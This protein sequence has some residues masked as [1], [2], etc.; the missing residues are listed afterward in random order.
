MMMI[1]P[2]GALMLVAPSAFIAFFDSTPA[3]PRLEYPS[4]HVAMYLSGGTVGSQNPS[5]GWTYGESVEI[6]ARGLYVDGRLEQYF[7]QPQHVGYATAHAGFILPSMHHLAG[8]VLVGYRAV[9][10]PAVNGRE[11]GV[12]VALPLVWSTGD[13][14]WRFES[15]YVGN[16]HG[17]NW[18]Y[19]VQGEWPLRRSRYVAGVKAE[20]MTLPIRDRSNI[21]WL[22]LTAV[23]GV[24]R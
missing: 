17:T 11:Q 14:W 23:I 20:T 13:R 8:G 22:T 15:F 24:H 12:E 1:F 3:P 10:G 6:L 9:R 2:A 16:T 7:L 5:S 19:R 21:S 18:N 4:N